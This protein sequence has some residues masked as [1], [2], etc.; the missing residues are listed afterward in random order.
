MAAAR[1]RG[2]TLR[3]APQQLRQEATLSFF[4]ALYAKQETEGNQIDEGLYLGSAAAG[5]DRDALLKRGITHILVCHPSLQKHHVQHFKYS[6]LPVQDG[7]AEN[8]LELLPEAL[9]FMLSSR[10]NRGAVFIYCM[11]G[12]SRSASAAIALLMLERQLSF[13]DAWRFCEKR[14]PIVYPNVGF[15]QQLRHLEKLIGQVAKDI[16]ATCSNGSITVDQ[17]VLEKWV[18]RLRELVPRGSLVSS[19]S[20]L[21]VREAM[22]VATAATFDALQRLAERCLTEPKLLNDQAT[23][24]RHGLFVENLHKYK[25]MP[26]DPRLL[27]RGKAVSGLLQKLIASRSSNGGRN[28]TS[29]AA[30]A[31]KE[32]DSWMEVVGPRLSQEPVPE[33]SAAQPAQTHAVA[34]FLGAYGD[35]AEEPPK[36]PAEGAGKSLLGGDYDS[37]DEEGEPPTGTVQSDAVKRSGEDG[38]ADR[39]TRQRTSK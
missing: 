25:A 3:H 7:P 17:A 18:C 20:P 35:D 16:P 6:R 10:R 32:I 8:L 34:A 29:F 9:E 1:S 37:S 27:S 5:E 13:D 31:A 24:K 30:A 11:K 36:E 33:D 19:Q 23:W 14:R 22:S 4:E 39:R 15:Q 28:A 26:G 12:I 2:G 38:E 21:R